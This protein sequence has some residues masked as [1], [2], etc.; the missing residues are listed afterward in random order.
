MRSVFVTRDLLL[1][2]KAQP[3]RPRIILA[4]VV[5]SSQNR[6][7]A[8]VARP[9]PMIIAA[10]NLWSRR[11]LK[12][13]TRGLASLTASAAASQRATTAPNPTESGD[14]NRV[15]KLAVSSCVTSPISARKIT[16]NVP[17][18]TLR[19]RCRILGDS[20]SQSAEDCHATLPPMMQ[21][22][23][24]SC[25]TR[26][27][28][29]SA[30]RSGPKLTA[31]VTCARN[32]V[33]APA[34]TSRGRPRKARIRLAN[35]VLSASS[36]PNTK[37]IETATTYRFTDTDVPTER[38]SYLRSAIDDWRT[39]GRSRPP[40]LRRPEDRTQCVSMSIHR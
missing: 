19:P 17:K 37:G 10:E 40:A 11:G 28:G 27:R 22:T 39:N 18:K 26:P 5:G 38:G 36:A 16:Q 7:E 4:S 15:A 20:G 30:N 21:L 23:A 8:L 31:I 3:G 6:K 29:M 1:H 9:N 25:V 32:A 34:H 33:A 12:R 13:K 35:I 14:R 2:D 24:R